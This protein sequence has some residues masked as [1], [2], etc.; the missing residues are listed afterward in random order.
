[1][2]KKKLI[3]SQDNKKNTTPLS[4]LKTFF[5]FRATIKKIHVI[6][7]F[8]LVPFLKQHIERNTVLQREA[9]KEGNK[10]KKQN[11]KLRNN[12]IFGKSTENPLNKV[13]VKL[14]TTRKQ[15]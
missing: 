14:V 3:P 12:A 10:I 1:M 7:K 6:L 4:K 2:V 15:F 5:K 9:E 13:A 8:K 11:A